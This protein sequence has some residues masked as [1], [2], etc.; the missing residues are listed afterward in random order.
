[1]ATPLDKLFNVDLLTIKPEHLKFLG[2]VTSLAVYESNSRVFDKNGLFSES[3]F[4]IVGTQERMTKAGYIDLKIPIIHP[5]AFK[6]LLDLDPIYDKIASGK[7]KASFNKEAKVFLED[8]KGSTGYEFLMSYLDQVEFRSTGAKSRDFAIA[9]IKKA[10]QKENL[11][12][13]FYVIPAGMRDI[14]LDA[15]GRPTQD[16]INTLYAKMIGSVNTIRN[17]SIKESNYSQFDPYRY[18]VQLIAMDIFYYIK[19]LLDGKKGFIQSKWASRGIMDGTRNVLTSLPTTVKDL[20]DPNKISFNDTTVGLYQFAK[21]ILPLAIHEITKYFVVG[22]ANP[23]NNNVKVIDSKTM[24]TTFKTANTKDKDYWTTTVGLNSILNKLKQDVI[25]NDYAKLGE[26]YIALVEDRG[27]EIYVVKD[28]NNIPNGVNVN[29]LRP[30][31]YGELIYISVAKVSKDVKATVTRYP[32]INLGSIYPSG[33][34]LKTT[35]NGRS[36]KVYLD[37]ETLELPEYPVL[38]EK[39]LQGTS[40]GLSHLSRL[41]ADKRKFYM[42]MVSIFK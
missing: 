28:T 40:A 1:M 21:S 42:L 24:K 16:E 37:N 12:R 17:N 6:Q 26:D 9:L 39:Y 13:Y 3:I 15:K 20:K 38:G 36:V 23:L 11:I 32:V 25:K 33:V 41:G 22:V 7:V 29:K 30:I 4:G 18:R 19:N 35:A 8:P 5:F 31:T 10:L 2:E 34:Y 27:K 14:E